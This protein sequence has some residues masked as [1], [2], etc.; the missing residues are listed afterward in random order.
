MRRTAFRKIARAILPDAVL[1]S[2]YRRYF[3]RTWGGLMQFG[4]FDSV[5]EA[6]AVAKSQGG[7]GRYAMDQAAWFVERSATFFPHDYPVLFWLSRVIRPG[8]RLVDLGGS[9]GVTYRLF[10]SR[11]ELPADFEW[12]V[13]EMP[14]VIAF[15][16]A[17]TNAEATP[18]LTFTDDWRAIDGASIVLSAG[19]VQFF[20]QSLSEMLAQVRLRPAHIVI[21]RLPLTEN[22]LRFITLQ[23]TGVAI[24][25]MRVESRPDFIA[26]MGRHRY[27]LVDEW[28]CLQNSLDVPFHQECDLT[29]FR[30]Y[31]FR[32]VDRVASAVG[33]V[34]DAPARE[35][36]T[37][38]ARRHPVLHPVPGYRTATRSPAGQVSSSRAPKRRAARH[39]RWPASCGAR[40]GSADV[41][42]GAIPASGG[43]P[44]AH[45]DHR[46]H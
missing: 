33:T 6:Q 34:A 32:R 25:P 1:E 2:R 18:H 17:L 45:S 29:Y 26:E 31:Y 21:N 43:S 24:A 42:H 38:R 14:E 22:G 27:E 35:A 13:N 4:R 28:K 44:P 9:T 46:T 11:L 7:D 40:W 5:D 23:N 16:R 10:K 20:P 3:F 15:A 41:R 12:Q 30:G 36:R 8:G 39:E 37:S 19:A